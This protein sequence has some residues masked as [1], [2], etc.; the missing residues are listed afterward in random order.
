MMRASGLSLIWH[1]YA[2]RSVCL[3]ALCAAGLWLAACAPTADP[4]FRDPEVQISATTRF[5]PRA[6]AGT[7]HVI[8]AYPTVFLPGCADQRW[9]ADTAT[10]PARFAVFCG[11]GGAAYDAPVAIDPRG[12]LQLQ[13]SDL[14]IPARAL[15]V[16]WM[17]EDAQ[18]AVIG[19]PSGEMGWIINRTPDL[20]ADRLTAAREIMAFNGYDVTD[21][22]GIEG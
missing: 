20:R 6:F 22:Q 16:M 5:S 3:W 13:S 14:D 2:R 15:W 12:A 1:V 7:W 19:T 21:L 8:E 4:G 9:Q 11:G 18:T 17:D 10:T